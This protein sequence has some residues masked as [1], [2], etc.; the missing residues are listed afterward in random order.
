MPPETD[1]AL[2]TEAFWKRPEPSSKGDSDGNTICQAVGRALSAWEEA[3]GALADL[4]CFV[5]RATSDAA[6]YRAVY[7]AYGAIHTSAGRREA[8]TAA[9]EVHFSPYW[10]K[11]KKSFTGVLDAVGQASKRRDDI[12]HGVVRSYVV[13]NEDFGAFLTPPEY[14]QGRTHAQMQGSEPLDFLRARYRYTSADIM[15]IAAKFRKLHFAVRDYSFK[16]MFRDG[17]IPLVDEI[18]QSE[19]AKRKSVPPGRRPHKRG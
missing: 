15:G 7:R 6:S 18:I 9:A 1:P 2:F 17:R 19:L 5:T 10:D 4:F 8:I 3:E 14:N 12:A 11:I 16:V 13:N